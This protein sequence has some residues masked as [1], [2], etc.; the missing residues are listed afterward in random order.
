[1]RR[2]TTHV[3]DTTRGLPAS[4]VSIELQRLEGGRW[5]T[6]ASA[7]TNADGRCDAPILDYFRARAGSSEASPF[8]DVVP[9]RFSLNEDSGHYH[10]PLVVAP[11][12]YST[13]RGT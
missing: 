13:Y 11:W 2:L 3:F 12:S 4:G 9:I 6:I 1:M 8:L 5:K 10:V 7:P